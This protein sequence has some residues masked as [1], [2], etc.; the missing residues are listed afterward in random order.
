MDPVEHAQK[1][2][3]PVQY[4]QLK[5]KLTL[6]PEFR[7]MK[8]RPRSE[9]GDDTITCELE[10]WGIF[11]APP[12]VALSY[13]WGKAFNIAVV[14]KQVSIN[15]EWVVVDG[16]WMQMGSNLVNALKT[17]RDDG[18]IGLLNECHERHSE[19]QNSVHLRIWISFSFHD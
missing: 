19:I 13:T 11:S 6:T 15:T 1:C 4:G 14:T 16:K 3:P 17:L 12:Y 10:A 7:L 8:I 5:G 9:S 2:E 18:L